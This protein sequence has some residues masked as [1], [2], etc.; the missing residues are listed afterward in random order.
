MLSAAQS[1]ATR[2]V[3]S[4]L[5]SGLLMMVCGGL[6]ACRGGSAPSGSSSATA[7]APGT[8]ANEVRVEVS[9]VGYDTEVSSSFVQLDDQTHRRSVQIAIGDDEAHAITLELHGLKTPRPL[10]GELLRQVIAHTGNA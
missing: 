10:T 6:A 5:V 7:S 2:W 3:G 8:P 4:M 1:I 9:D